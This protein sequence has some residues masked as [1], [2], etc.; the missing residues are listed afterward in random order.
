V[1]N[2]CLRAAGGMYFPVGTV[3]LEGSCSGS[4]DPSVK[5]SNSDSSEPP[6]DESLWSISCAAEDIG[7]L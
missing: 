6:R 2:W 1:V 3:A 5:P 4:S 7:D